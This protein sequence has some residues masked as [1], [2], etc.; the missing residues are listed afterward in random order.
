MTNKEV[1][2]LRIGI[3]RCL[4]IPGEKFAYAIMKNKNKVDSYIKNLEFKYREKKEFLEYQDE[5]RKAVVKHAKKKEDGSYETT[6]S[7]ETGKPEQVYVI[8]DQKALDAENKELKKKFATAIK[9]REKQIKSFEK[10]VDKEADIKLHLI[11]SVPE[12]ITANQLE[13]ILPLIKK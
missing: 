5:L 2:S 6:L 11:E 7:Y 1:Y 12:N 9:E 13:G 10:E 8:G 4:D 3:Q